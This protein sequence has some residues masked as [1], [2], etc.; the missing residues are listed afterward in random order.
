MKDQKASIAESAV[1]GKGVSIG[2]GTVIWQ[3]THIREN[4]VIGIQCTIGEGVYIGP[5]V[6]IG[7]NVKIQ[8]GA[9]IFQPAVIGDGCFIGPLAILTNDRFPR[10][11]SETGEKKTD[12]D[13]SA[14]SIV[15][16]KGASLGAG[17]ICVAPALI[18]RNAMVGAGSIVVSDIPEGTTYVGN[19][20][21]PISNTSPDTTT[22]S[23]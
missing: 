22:P 5:G 9:Q 17:V 13:W 23:G 1:I 8:N 7:D 2:I 4:C 18:G 3:N 15:V 11:L 14:D 16:E 20:A 10:A 6:R 19:P 21:G 12:N